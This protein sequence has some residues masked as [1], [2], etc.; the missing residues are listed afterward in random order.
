MLWRYAG[1]PSAK[2]TKLFN[3]FK[4]VNGKFSKKSDTYKAI[5]WAAETGISKGYSKQSDLPAGSGYKAPCY[6]C[7]LECLREQMIVFLYRFVTM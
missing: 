1:K 5:M 4:D 3:S 2:E 6:G 7:D